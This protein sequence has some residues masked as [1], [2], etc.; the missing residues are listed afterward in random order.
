M[1]KFVLEK[2]TNFYKSLFQQ[3]SITFNSDLKAPSYIASQQLWYNRFITINNKTVFFPQWSKSK[4]NFIGQ[5]FDE[6][7]LKPWNELKEEFSLAKT[8]HFKY[9]QLCNAIPSSWKTSL[10]KDS[11][12]THGLV[13]YEPHIVIYQTVHH[14]FKLRAK[15][16]YNLLLGKMEC[17][18]TAQRCFSNLFTLSDDFY[19]TKIYDL[20]RKTTV[21]TR[22]RVFQYKIL[23]NVLY[24]N[25]KL[26]H[27][28]LVDSEKCRFCLVSNETP[29]HIFSE[30]PIVKE[31]WNCLCDV[32]KDYVSLP[33]L[34]PQSA[35]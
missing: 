22:L 20:P 28:G 14:I 29:I 34:S 18:P 27:F 32:F 25:E 23:N 35:T 21:D 2:F 6:K 11:E 15:F 31:L 16:L 3:W 33:N 19:W 30:C 5:L 12:N 26:F 9:M 8:D 10:L 24:L 7:K 13:L 1:H 4:L 17:R